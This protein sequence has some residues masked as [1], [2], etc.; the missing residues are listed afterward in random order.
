MLSPLCHPLPGSPGRVWGAPSAGGAGAWRARLGRS[1]GRKGRDRSVV[2]VWWAWPGQSTGH[3][4]PGPGGASRS[5]NASTSLQHL[6]PAKGDLKILR[7]PSGRLAQH[8]PSAAAAA[9]VQVN[10]RGGPP[11][12]CLPGG[13]TR[14]AAA[15]A[16]L[17]QPPAPGS[18]AFEA[19]GSEYPC[20]SPIWTLASAPSQDSCVLRGA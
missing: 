3:R 15:S 18:L 9:R 14:R 13:C 16:R 11:S 17:L 1:S 20:L 8:K 2:G 12:R 4:G 10:T 7:S 6:A 19:A 5:L